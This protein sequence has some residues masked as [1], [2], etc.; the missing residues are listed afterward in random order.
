MVLFYKDSPE[1]LKNMSYP[2]LSQRLY[3]I[4]AFAC[5]D[6]SIRMWLFWHREARAKKVIRDSSKIEWETGVPLLRISPGTYQA[7]TLFAGIDF[8]ISIDGKIT[9]KE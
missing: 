4:T 1:E 5:E 3:K 7:H 2:Q 6:K 8:E 9:F